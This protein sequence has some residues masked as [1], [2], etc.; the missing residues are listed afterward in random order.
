MP[1]MRLKPA[2]WGNVGKIIISGGSGASSKLAGTR[3]DKF[4]TLRSNLLSL[5]PSLEPMNL[6]KCSSF[7]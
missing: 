3:R 7:Q 4:A 2:I 1:D 5:A 6:K